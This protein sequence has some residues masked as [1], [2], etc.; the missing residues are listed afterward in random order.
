M[1]CE[2]IRD[3]LDEY[4]LDTLDLA[5]RI[6][7][8]RHLATCADCRQIVEETTRA[9]SMLPSAL[10]VA[11]SVEPPQRIREQLLRNVAAQSHSSSV[12]QQPPP[13]QPVRRSLPFVGQV[14]G[15][16]WR[17]VASITIVLFIASFTWGIRL[18][19]ALEEERQLRDEHA[20][21]LDE[22]VG[23]QEIVFEVIGFDD[24]SRQFLRPQQPGSTS[25]GKLFTRPSMPYV[26]VMA[27]RLPQPAAGETFQL[28]L[29]RG[30][31]TILGGELTIDDHGFGLLVFSADQPGPVYDSAV[32][33][34]QPS[35]GTEPAGL[36]IL[37]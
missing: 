23:E 6:E 24:T 2:Q 9:L 26:V 25:Y 14:A 17:L 7:V 29:T 32:V 36:E 5:Q 22:V 37:R 28:W 11:S 33:T 20:A 27:G 15:L 3:L 4:A 16:P 1:D 31:E 12:A 34:L 13:E 18:A 10:A 21:L 8:E 30:G 19:L 35:G